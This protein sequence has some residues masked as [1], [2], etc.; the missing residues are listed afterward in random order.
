M[1]EL[2]ERIIKRVEQKFNGGENHFAARGVLASIALGLADAEV[3]QDT[4]LDSNER[5]VRFLQ[6]RDA[7]GEVYALR[8]DL[9]N[10]DQDSTDYVRVTNRNG[11]DTGTVRG[12]TTGRVILRATTAEIDY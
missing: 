6:S 12:N 10:G 11:V 1:P 7:E 4:L 2:S 9:G 8:A 5:I 3:R